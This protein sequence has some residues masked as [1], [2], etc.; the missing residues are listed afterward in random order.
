MKKTIIIGIFLTMLLSCEAIFVE[1]ISDE[2]VE[3]LAPKS[4]LTVDAGS[5]TFSWEELE[6]TDEYHLK[7]ATPNFLNAS[8]IVLDTVIEKRFFSQS[9]S[10]GEYEWTIIG[11]N[12]EYETLE[13][14][15]K[16][17]IR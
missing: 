4:E 9:L 1:N 8:Q 12:S 15:Y 16:L 13:E 14:I 10:T 3:V 2:T 5:I 6:G 17:T 7:I 11:K